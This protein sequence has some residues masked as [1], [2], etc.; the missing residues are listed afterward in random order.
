MTMQPVRKKA[1][2]ALRGTVGVA[3]AAALGL[4]TVAPAL[5]T[6]TA[7]DGPTEHTDMDVTGADALAHLQELS[8][9]SVANAS[10]GCRALGT[11]GYEQA[12]EYVEEVLEAT[13]AYEV[14][15][16]YFEVEDQEFGEVAFSVGYSDYDVETFAYTE[17]ADPPLSDA[18]LA[19][20]VD[21]AYGDG[22]G[23][24]LGCSVDDFVD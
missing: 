10:D 4:T 3:A 6:T 22:A 15:R 24:E 14:T 2:R 12:S 7:P 23:G 18:V 1:G 16:D 17:A 9:I 19:L 8:D 20:P 11:V 13:G 21:D 5:A